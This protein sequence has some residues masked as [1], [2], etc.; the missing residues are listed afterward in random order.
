MLYDFANFGRN[1]PEEVCNTSHIY[2]SPYVVTCV[3]IIPCKTSQ[4]FLLNL[5]SNMKFVS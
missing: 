3:R 4:D 2:S 5:A 1:I